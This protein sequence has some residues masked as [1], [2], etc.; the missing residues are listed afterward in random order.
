MSTPEP[1]PTAVDL[2]GPAGPAAQA[3]AYDDAIAV[4]DALDQLDRPKSRAT[5]VMPLG[6]LVDADGTEIVIGQAVVEVELDPAGVLAALYATGERP[7]VT[8]Y[9]TAEITPAGGKAVR[10]LADLVAALDLAGEPT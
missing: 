9:V 8:T 4:L 3:R 7:P 5:L 1:K 6:K 10:E 2:G